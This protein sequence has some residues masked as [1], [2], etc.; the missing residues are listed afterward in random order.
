[1]EETV[2]ER[3]TGFAREAEAA[4]EALRTHY[5][6]IH[7]GAQS[8]CSLLF[9]TG[10]ALMLFEATKPTAPWVFLAGSVT[11]ATLPAIRLLHEKGHRAIRGRRETAS[12]E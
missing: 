10:S 2:P 1:M 12:E 6:W 11:F 9:V 4:L 8:I 5:F 7:L 3:I